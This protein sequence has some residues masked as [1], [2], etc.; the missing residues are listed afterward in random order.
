MYRTLFLVGLFASI[1]LAV[2][3]EDVSDTPDKAKVTSTKGTAR[4]TLSSA[5]DVDFF[6]FD[7]RIDY[8][9]KARDTSGNITVILS[10]KSPPGTNPQSGWRLELYSEN[11]LA[12]SLYTAV[13]PET[14]IETEFEQG[15]SP[16]RYY[17]K[18]SSVDSVVFP[19]KEYTIKGAWEEST[20]YEK[21]P[22]DKPNNATAMRVNED[23]YGNLS[24]TTDVDYYRFSLQVPDVVTITLSQQT[25][26]FDPQLGWQ[27][28]LL[29]QADLPVNLPS[30]LMQSQPLQAELGVGD[31]Y[32]FV[33]GLPPQEEE[34]E[35]KAPIGQRYQLKVNAPTVAPPAAECPFVFTY[36]VNPHTTHWATFP[37]PCDVPPGWFSQ[38]EPPDAFETCPARYAIYKSPIQAKDGI[39]NL[40]IPFVDVKDDVGNEYLFRVIMQ[41]EGDI[42]KLGEAKLIRIL[43]EAPVEEAAIEQPPVEQPQP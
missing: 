25:P 13:L 11:N 41:Q 39:G 28:G 1:P 16:G 31:H 32:V 10:Q 36:A 6:R 29:S 24:S 21:Q 2:I 8:K 35:M 12:H 18:V 15:L 30:T 26:G 33:K 20:N 40:N 34:V 14:S 27:F 17:Y 5:T 37:T 7:V 22:N 42:F 9:N 4:E 43:K 23:Y 3:A 38:P 19:A